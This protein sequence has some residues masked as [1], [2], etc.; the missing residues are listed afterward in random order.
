MYTLH[1]EQY[2]NAY[3]RW[4]K[5]LNNAELDIYSGLKKWKKIVQ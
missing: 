3:Q 4:H 1:A 5:G 2:P